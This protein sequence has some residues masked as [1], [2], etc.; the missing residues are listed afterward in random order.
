MRILKLYCFLIILTSVKAQVKTI[1]LRRPE[2]YDTQ[3]VVLS[4]T[5]ES[6]IM[7]SF[8][9]GKI[10]FDAAIAKA[11]NRIVTKGI[12][13]KLTTVN[14]DNKPALIEVTRDDF[15]KPESLDT[16]YYEGRALPKARF[17]NIKT[18]CDTDGSIIILPQDVYDIYTLVALQMVKQLPRFNPAQ[19]NGEGVPVY[20]TIPIRFL[21][22]VK[23]RAM[24]DADAKAVIDKKQAF[25]SKHKCFLR[26][27]I[28]RMTH[29]NGQ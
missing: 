29:R 20:L 27:W 3:H 9:N 17:V 24:I 19:Y 28:W 12:P 13:Q 22:E 8:G 6:H 15:G 5:N 16:G 10:G 7:P 21:N 26:R 1:T 23:D 4:F 14:I 25:Y 2:P 18:Y 11:Y